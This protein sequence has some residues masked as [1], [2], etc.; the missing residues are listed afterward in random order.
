MEPLPCARIMSPSTSS[1]T[2]SILAT[3]VTSIAKSAP[4]KSRSP[5]IDSVVTRGSS[6]SIKRINP[7]NST[8]VGLSRG[9]L[10]IVPAFVVA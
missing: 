10:S 4:K 7:G 8:A 3:G 6:E 1:K 9:I 2:N 5:S